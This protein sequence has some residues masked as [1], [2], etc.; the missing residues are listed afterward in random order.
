MKYKVTYYKEGKLNL[1]K[2]AQ[3]HATYYCS[4]YARR[5][6]RYLFNVQ[7]AGNQ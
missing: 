2:T 5:C 6:K 1:T 4:L 3:S 7:S